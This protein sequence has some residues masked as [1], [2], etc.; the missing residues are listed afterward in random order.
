MELNFDIGDVP[1]MLILAQR[2]TNY[3]VDEKF[4]FLSTAAVK[5]RPVP[6]EEA[7]LCRAPNVDSKSTSK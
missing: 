4:P 1:A 7:Q 5:K 6:D 2:F 3:L